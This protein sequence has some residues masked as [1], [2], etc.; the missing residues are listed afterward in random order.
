MDLC[1]KLIHRRGQ[2]MLEEYGKTW[3]YVYLP[4]LTFEKV[5]HYVKHGT[6]YDVSDQGTI[7][8]P[9]RN[10][11]AIEAKMHCEPGE[12]KPSFW[13]LKE[14]EKCAED[15]S[16]SRLGCVQEVNAQSQHQHIHRGVGI[17]SVSMEVEGSPCPNDPS[18][19]YPRE[20]DEANLTFTLVSA[21]TWGVTDCVAHIV[22]APNKWHESER[23]DN[24][25]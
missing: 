24:R 9:N 12:P 5:L 2:P 10:L 1:P 17:F 20:G 22:H 7:D 4:Q 13:V 6:G 16:F 23:D 8:D 11:V 25:R 3:V 18:K 15:M 19:P 21:R 14:N